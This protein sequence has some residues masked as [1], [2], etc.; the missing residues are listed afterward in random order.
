MRGRPYR[1]A[2]GGKMIGLSAPPPFRPRKGNIGGAIDLPRRQPTAPT[3]QRRGGTGGTTSRS[4]YCEGRPVTHI[5]SQA[6]P[7][8]G[9]GSGRKRKMCIWPSAGGGRGTPYYWRSRA[10]L[11]VTRATIGARLALSQS[12]L[13]SYDLVRCAPLKAERPASEE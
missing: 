8:E 5:F 11:S 4:D 6:R 2:S 1:P 12:R 7:T 10:M 9:S 3:E 13:S